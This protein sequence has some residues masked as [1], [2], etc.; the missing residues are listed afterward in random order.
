MRLISVQ[1]RL[2]GLRLGDKHRP[3]L[4][5]Q[6]LVF[7]FQLFGAADSSVKNPPGCA[8]CSAAADCPGLLHKIAGRRG[9]MASTASS[10]LPQAR[11]HHH[12]QLAVE[13]LECATEAS[14]PSCPEVVSRW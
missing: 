7:R 4:R 6:Q 13:R 5:A 2:H 1:Q 8:R 3:V 10:T 14:M 11:H 9:A 12:R